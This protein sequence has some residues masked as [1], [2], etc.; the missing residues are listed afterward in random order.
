MD[1]TGRQ[2]GL[3]AGASGACRQGSSY[4]RNWTVMI[5]AIIAAGNTSA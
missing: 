3:T 4:T 1:A 5:L 2:R